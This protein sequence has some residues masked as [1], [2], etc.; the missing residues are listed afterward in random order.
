M[1]ILKFGGASLSNAMGFHQIKSWL[2]HLK[3]EQVILVVSALFGVT[4]E[5]FRLMEHA[6]IK[7]LES[8][9]DGITRL[10]HRHTEV[11][12][13][14]QLER[15]PLQELL[16]EISH[17]MD[18]LQAMLESCAVLREVSPRAQDRI[19]SA[20]ERLSSLMAA[21]FL[22]A[23]GYPS[24]KVAGEEALITDE[25]YTQALPL[26]EET[27]QQCRRFIR[28]ILEEGKIPV[29]AGF[30]GR[31]VDGQTTTLGR[32]GTDFSATTLAQA[33]G[34]KEV[35]FLKETTGVL[36]TDPKM[37]PEAI[38]LDALSFEEMAEL[39]WFGARVLHPIAMQPLKESGIPA[40]IRS[41]AEIENIGTLVSPEASV[42]SPVKAITAISQ[43]AVVAVCGLGMAGYPGMAARLFQALATHK[44]NVLMI[45]QSSSEQNICLVLMKDQARK[46]RQ[47]LEEEFRYEIAH[48]RIDGVE[49]REDMAVIALVGAGMRGTPGVAGKVFG[50][51][52][53]ASV[54]VFLIAQG[55]SEFNISFAIQNSQ[56]EMALKALHAR[57]CEQGAS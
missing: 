33:L 49:V 48:G 20:G 26:K 13:D 22:T 39:S 29:I 40:R 47:A 44:I 42:T 55:S 16:E 5:L 57:L 23:S 4:N 46:A 3:G 35:W 1:Y 43:A 38:H 28:P 54:N 11:A 18:E 14:L 34:A 17:E 30:T 9:H 41:F 24:R 6:Q 51:L 2:E 8:L 15:Q 56:M 52:G 7:D 31:T 53:E 27:S 32:G 45:S 50:T 10:R 21:R 37:V 25:N 36:S 12:R 19:A